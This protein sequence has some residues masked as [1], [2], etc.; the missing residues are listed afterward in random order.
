MFPIIFQYIEI[1][2][3]S[4]TTQVNEQLETLNL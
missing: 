2:G 1:I 4:N 3:N